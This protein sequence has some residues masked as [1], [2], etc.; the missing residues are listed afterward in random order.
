VVQFTLSHQ[1]TNTSLDTLKV[2]SKKE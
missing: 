1:A 2:W